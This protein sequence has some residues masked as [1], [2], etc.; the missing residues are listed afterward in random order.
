M[1]N[2]LCFGDSNTFGYD[3]VNDSRFPWGVRWT[4]LVQEKLGNDCR[5][6]EE[7]MG[8]RTTVWDDPVEQLQC[9]KNYLYS[10][11]ESHWPLDLV[12]IMLG[13]NDLK[14]RFGLSACEI[15]GGVETLV[16]MVRWFFEQKKKNVPEIL[17]ISPIEVE[18]GIA[19]LPYGAVMGGKTAARRSRELPQYYREVAKRNRCW[20]MAAS[21]FAK[22]CK[23]DCMHLDREGHKKLADAITAKILEIRA[24]VRE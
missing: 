14:M 6:I 13:T 3:T 22:P 4:S 16:Q 19:E 23:E 18:E 12:I 7:G 9:G 11:L 17:I 5:I 21:E 1:W 15:A 2:I 24:S 20:F 10:C 8:G